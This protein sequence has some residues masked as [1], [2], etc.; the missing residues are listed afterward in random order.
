MN[1]V[2]FTNTHDSLGDCLQRSADFNAK[3]FRWLLISAALERREE[4]SC[5]AGCGSQC[6]SL[7]E[8]DAVPGF[9]APNA[10]RDCGQARL[11]IICMLGKVSMVCWP[12]M[13]GQV[14][15]RVSLLT[16]I[17]PKPPASD[18]YGMAVTS[19][20]PGLY[21]FPAKPGAGGG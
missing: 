6:A 7:L 16:R 3:V 4:T 8:Q 12:V 20:P 21:G 11:V 15:Q 17:M 5:L 9:T 19:T 2:G 10:T 13:S 1:L 18:S 14:L